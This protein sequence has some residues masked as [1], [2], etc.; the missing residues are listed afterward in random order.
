MD[1]A[2]QKQRTDVLCAR[3]LFERA[4]WTTLFSPLGT[5]FVAWMQWDNVGL[6]RI[7]GWMA[8]NT[9]FDACTLVVSHRV[10]RPGTSDARLLYW[11][12][13]QTALRA[14][15]GLSW[16]SASVVFHIAGPEAFI[17]D[18]MILVVLIAVAMVGIINLAP[19]FIT[20]VL[21][22]G[23]VLVVPALLYAWI[24]DAQHVTFT[25]GLL[26]LM[27]IQLQAGWDAYTQHRNGAR[28]LVVNQQMSSDL[29]DS[30]ASVKI[31]NATLE[32]R[33]QELDQLNL[34]LQHMAMHDKLTGL[35]NRHFIVQVLETQHEVFQRHGNPCSILLMD[36]D[37]FKRV[38]DTFGHGVGDRVLTAFAQCVQPLLRQ[39]EYFGRIGGEEFILVM[40]MSTLEA[41]VML[42]QRIRHTLAE[43]DLLAGF[44]D[45]WRVTASIGVAEVSTQEDMET[46]MARADMALYRAKQQG[47]DRVEV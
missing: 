34:A 27:G 47:R 3:A 26:I 7:L 11:L 30:V 45:A 20:L 29:A 28:L 13:V 1:D 6:S 40:P 24:G 19:S 14:L 4:R 15:Q 9:V 31:A 5:L 44:A 43:S 18:L 41:A 46:W 12:K 37:H 23:G 2:E 21:Y 25:V 22:T 16:G 39:S 8:L 33:N 10:L 42:A 38:N 32:Q 35:Y 17:N 36:L